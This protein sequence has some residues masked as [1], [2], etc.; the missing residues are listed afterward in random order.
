MS[1]LLKSGS[2]PDADQLNA[3]VEH[4][5]PAHEKQQTLAHLAVCPDCR[6]IVALALPSID[7]A[8][9]RKAARKTWFRGWNV[10][11]LGVPALAAIAFLAIILPKSRNN[12][13]L[14]DATRVTKPAQVAVTHAPAPAQSFDLSSALAL[15]A[16][17]QHSTHP[18]GVVASASPPQKLLPNVQPAPAAVGTGGYGPRALGSLAIS[19]RNILPQ[20]SLPSHL[21]VLSIAASGS[22]QL[23]IDT[24]NALFFSTDE[25]RHWRA[26][27][28][29]WLGRAV[30]VSLIAESAVAD[31]RSPQN[32][33]AVTGVVQAQRVEVTSPGLTG[34]ITDASGAVIPNADV[35]A[36]DTG[37]AP[38][39]AEKT[40]H[41]GRF[42]I[43]NLAPGTY[44]VDAVAPGFTKKSVVVEIAPSQP[45]SINLTLQVGTSSQTVE[46][47]A[48]AP[49]IPAGEP[50]ATFEIKTDTGDRWT[51]TDGLTWTHR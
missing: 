1:D 19:G 7:E 22:K 38:V 33:E 5:L 48:A 4:T 25:G 49:S 47:T 12:N 43:P 27:A 18:K 21:P 11:W 41:E 50:P 8:A 36:H 40:D 2:H 46:V 31:I 45:A 51:S 15:S 32:A 6:S 14:N 3:F 35:V 42:A 20:A 10:A 34:T 24:A 37:N 39:R 44:K 26:V 13:V 23:A 16:P 29:Q 17:K 9:E 30:Q 28:P